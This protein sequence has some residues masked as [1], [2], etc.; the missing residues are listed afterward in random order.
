MDHKVIK[1]SMK[2]VVSDVDDIVDAELQVADKK[3][4]LFFNWVSHET[5]KPVFEIRLRI[6]RWQNIVFDQQIIRIT[7]DGS[8]VEQITVPI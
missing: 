3:I 7:K 6:K 1:S 2:S 8:I 5:R 4:E